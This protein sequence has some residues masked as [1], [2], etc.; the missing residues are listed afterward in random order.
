MNKKLTEMV[1]FMLRNPYIIKDIC[2]RD[3]E[4]W[5]FLKEIGCMYRLII[6]KKEINEDNKCPCVERGKNE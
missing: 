3:E 2:Y 6:S 5:H 1:D 4:T